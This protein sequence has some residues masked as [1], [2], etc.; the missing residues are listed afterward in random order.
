MA[1]IR[2]I[3]PDFFA[4]EDI[5]EMPP[6]CRIAFA[7]L[8]CHADREGRLEDRPKRLKPKVLPYDD[9]DMHDVLDTLAQHGFIQRYEVDGHRFI[10]VR[11]FL[12]HQ[13]PNVKEPESTIPAQCVDCAETIPVHEST[14]G[15]GMG[16]GM[17]KE[18]NGKGRK[19]VSSELAT[20]RHSEPSSD[21]PSRV[22]LEFPTVG[23]GGQVWGLTDAQIAAWTAAYPSIDILAEAQKALA[24]VHANPGRRKTSGGMSRFLVSW[25]NRATD[26]H[27][28]TGAA[29]GSATKRQA[30]TQHNHET[31][32]RALARGGDR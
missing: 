16:K 5:A 23:T 18:G 3:K 13:C 26:H 28:P 21:P 20:P 14:C 7:G 8:W 17:G 19:N 2:T 24:W 10:Q 4:D 22:V 30:L 11:T 27:G 6:L 31:L 32:Q 1:R 9:V 29:S 15:M 25:L 12:K